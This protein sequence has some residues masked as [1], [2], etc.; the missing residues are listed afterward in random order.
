MKSFELQL[1]TTVDAILEEL[2]KGCLTAE[3]QRD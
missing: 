2:I 3:I 1:V